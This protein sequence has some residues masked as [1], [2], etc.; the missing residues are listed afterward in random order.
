MDWPSI[1]ARV[2]QRLG[3]KPPTTTLPAPVKP[4]VS[5]SKL[6]AAAQHDPQAKGTPVTYAGTKIVEAALVD[7]G[8]LAKTRLDG[9]YG[10][11][12]RTAM[13]EWQESLGYRGRKPGQPADGIPGKDS[14]TRLGTKHGFTVVA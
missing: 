6:I 7:E 9:H 14:L 12:T 4:T 5:L 8:K 11:D 13:S 1:L 3:S 10:T 2:A